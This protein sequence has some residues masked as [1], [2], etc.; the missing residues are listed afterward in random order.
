[1]SILR[2]L[3]TILLP[4]A[5]FLLLSACQSLP[6]AEEASQPAPVTRDEA[7][8]AS[9]PPAPRPTRPMQPE[10]LDLL[11]EAELAGYRGDTLG[12]LDNYL[13][14]ARITRDVELIRYSLALA[15]ELGATDRAMQAAVLWH[16]V[17]P[18]NP[19]ALASAVQLLARV[20]EAESAWYLAEQ[21]DPALIRALALET[22][23]VGNFEQMV[24][25][26]E[27]I[28]IW[29]ALH[30]ENLDALAARA[31]MADLFGRHTEAA[32]LAIQAL[33]LAPADA[34]AMQIRAD[35]LIKSGNWQT[36]LDELHLYLQQF[37]MQVEQNETL[38]GLYYRLPADAAADSLQQL[39][40][41][42]P[43][44]QSLLIMT[45]ETQLRANSLDQAESLYREILQME[46]H[47]NMARFQ[48]ASLAE[49]RGL[50]ADAVQQYAEVEL[51]SYYEEAQQRIFDLLS[52]QNMLEALLE[53]MSIQRQRYPRIAA[54]L[55]ALQAQQLAPLLH[56]SDLMSFYDVAVSQHPDSLDLRYARSLLTENLDQLDKAETDLRRI[57]QVEPDDANALNALGYTLANRTDR[58][59]EAFD[60]IR[61]A[62]ELD[63]DNPAIQDSMG[64]VLYKLGRYEEALQYLALAQAAYYD[65]EVI[66]HHAEVLFVMD[67]I[68]EALDLIAQGM[69]DFP[70]DPLLREVRRRILDSF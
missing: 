34:L 67:R 24:W 65:P 10:V 25:L 29:S 70:G 13:E 63:P 31:M 35:A 57:L 20:G 50:L 64:W 62:I 5:A 32:Q 58:Y 66:A 44:S 14:A 49:K 60:L 3:R 41:Q 39:L 47:R 12:A 40:N 55:F 45:A 22:A 51:G 19:D 18:D 26:D 11:L 46:P 37:L 52:A 69:L 2:F 42:H 53:Q 43:Q 8:A 23:A 15:V 17:E 30:P 1:M 27:E 33:Q 7:P 48:L 36:A 28:T 59:E 21:G 68:D 61:R 38:L 4:A 6:P 9:V 56:P 54:N 16:E